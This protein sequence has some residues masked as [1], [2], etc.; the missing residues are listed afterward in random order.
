[1]KAV[2]LL[3]G[4]IPLPGTHEVPEDHLTHYLVVA[5]RHNARP[6]WK[7]VTRRVIRGYKDPYRL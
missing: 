6:W 5:S 7:R 1:M 4:L 2:T 3:F